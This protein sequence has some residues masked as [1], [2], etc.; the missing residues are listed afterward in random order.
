MAVKNEKDIIPF[1]TRRESIAFPADFILYLESADRNIIV[2][3]DKGNYRCYKNLRDCEIYLGKDYFRV[4]ER[5]IVNFSRVL[6]MKDRT[7]K[8]DNG[9][10]VVVGDKFFGSLR[11]RFSNYIIKKR[12]QQLG[13]E[14]PSNGGPG[15]LVVSGVERDSSF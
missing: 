7:I 14:E 9:I 3:T 6:L 2:C 13:L 11:R 4:N 15:C 5:M 12:R 10:E 1:V 8:F